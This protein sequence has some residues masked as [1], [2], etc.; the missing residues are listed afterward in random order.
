MSNTISYAF[1]AKTFH[2]K[3]VGGILATAG[4]IFLL[5]PEAYV[6]DGMLIGLVMIALGAGV[7]LVTARTGSGKRPRLIVDDKGIWHRDWGLDVVPW[8]AISRVYMR[9]P[10]FKITICVELKDPESFVAAMAPA[11]RSR[12]RSKPLV[13]LPVL[14]IPPKALDATMDELLTALQSG[15]Q[16]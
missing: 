16:T 15:L 8:D 4:V 3:V 1:H 13:R 10:R 2:G 14:R 5:A 6:P 9:G 11:D 7:L 12:L